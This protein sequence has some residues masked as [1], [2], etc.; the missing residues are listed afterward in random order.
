M[1]AGDDVGN[2]LGFRGIRHRRFEHA[3]DGGGTRAEPDVLAQHVGIALERRRPVSIGQ[4][5]GARGS[6]AIVVRVEKAA[7]DRMQSHDAEIRSAHHA[8]AYLARLA[9]A[10]HR[11]PHGRELPDLAQR[12]DARAQ[13]LDF[14]HGKSSVLGSDA[15]GALGDINQP[16]F[17]A[18]DQGTQQHAANQGK[19]GRVGSNSQRQRE[20]DRRRKAF[21]AS[22]RAD[23]EL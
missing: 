6:R 11:E 1:R 14:R 22:Q 4:H 7:E 10:D 17:I 19:N 3:D 20:D 23:G 15:A 16:V 18:V 21:G 13:I 2:D 5:G 9:Q 8:G 12:F